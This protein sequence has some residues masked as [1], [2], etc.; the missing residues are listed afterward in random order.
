MQS[1][2]APKYLDI[3]IPSYN[4][5]ETIERCLHGVTKA[6][7][8]SKRERLCEAVHIYIVDDGST[9]S[10]LE[11][12]QH[13][14][15]TSIYPSTLIKQSQQGPS[16]ARNSG[17]K[18]G[19]ASWILYIDSDVEPHETALSNL[20]QF[21]RIQSDCLAINGHP[22]QYVPNGSW[23]T[24]YTNL[25]LCYQL[26]QHGSRVNTAFTSLCLMSRDAWSEMGGWDTSRTSRYSDDIQSRWYFPAD[27]IAQCF[28]SLFIH[29]KHVR[30]FGLIKHR[31]NLGFHFRSSISKELLSG[32][33][34]VTLHRRY[35]VNVLCALI[36]V[37]SG[38][39]TLFYPKLWTV[40]VLWWLPV[41][42][43]NAP[44]VQFIRTSK[45]HRFST[46]FHLLSIFGLS[47]CEGF[48]MGLGLSYSLCKRQFD[49][50]FHDD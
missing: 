37:I 20:L 30:L 19:T 39:I 36:S 10:S 2:T 1:S 5:A 33:S 43:V 26:K 44:L 17:T 40:N 48:A 13:F 8:H 18:V 49:G 47:Y 15:N 23:I 28:E 31:F 4:S 50:R 29:H 21:Y 46:P 12:I 3:V 14:T 24:Q 34:T 25:S 45:D 42:I 7:A 11:Y 32:S 22:Q 27:S 35:P 38:M 9:D 16:A 6:I 41:L